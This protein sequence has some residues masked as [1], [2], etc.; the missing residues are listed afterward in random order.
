MRHLKYVILLVLLAALCHAQAAQPDYVTKV[1]QTPEATYLQVDIPSFASTFLMGIAANGRITGFASVDPAPNSLPSQYLRAA[2]F[3]LNNGKTTFI[4]HPDPGDPLK[5]LPTF[6]L[7]IRTNGTV[8]GW[9]APEVEPT[10]AEL[11]WVWE[12]GSFRD[13]MYEGPDYDQLPDGVLFEKVT[14]VMSIN[15][16]GDMVGQVGYIDPDDPIWGSVWRGWMS[17]K[18]AF[19]L[20]DPPGAALTYP[21]DINER[22]EVVGLYRT[23]T[24]PP[25]RYGFLRSPDGR[26][27][28]IIFPAPPGESTFMTFPQAINNQGDVAGFYAL[29]PGS[30][31]GFLLKGDRYTLIDVPDAIHTVVY[32]I[33]ETGVIVG[34]FKDSTGVHGFIRIPKR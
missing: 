14:D 27:K 22:G 26:I 28:D 7:K 25:S 13:V 24:M 32:G 5:V 2:G 16:R 18:G 23:M 3:V 30:P 6:P 8:T 33:D 19:Q 4:A 20:I 1:V 34:T 11:G 10:G 29:V 9:S 17:R 31:R 12:R 15:G 21:A